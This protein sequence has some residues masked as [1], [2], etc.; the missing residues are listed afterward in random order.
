M[1]L[2][3]A[4]NFRIKSEVMAFILYKDQLLY[5]FLNIVMYRQHLI[6]TMEQM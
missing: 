2:F 1:Q 3:L 6:H 4:V 5:F